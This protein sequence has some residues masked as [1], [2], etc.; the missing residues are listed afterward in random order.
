MKYFNFYKYIINTWV[1]FQ[2]HHLRLL[3]SYLVSTI[4]NFEIRLKAKTMV[5]HPGL[6]HCS[7]W[8]LTIT[9]MYLCY[10][11]QHF[12]FCVILG[13]TRNIVPQIRIIIIDSYWE[14]VNQ[15]QCYHFQ[16]Y[17]YHQYPAKMKNAY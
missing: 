7:Y 9:L 8:S 1:I 15:F 3:L 16:K 4:T 2:D 13:N 14:N 5:R 6:F 10:I 11:Y 17:F 12:H